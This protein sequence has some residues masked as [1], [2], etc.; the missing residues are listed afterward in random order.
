MTVLNSRHD[1]ETPPVQCSSR[2][3]YV[4]GPIK[5]SISSHVDSMELLNR[6]IISQF[7]TKPCGS[8]IGMF[9]FYFTLLYEISVKIY[10]S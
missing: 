3:S 1:G 2:N 4:E 8:T 5:S 6:L 10:C 9:H 7:D